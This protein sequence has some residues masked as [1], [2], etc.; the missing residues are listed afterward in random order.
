MN[1]QFGMMGALP[2]SAPKNRAGVAPHRADTGR[3]SVEI[4]FGIAFTQT[5]RDRQLLLK[6][7]EIM[8]NEDY[9]VLAQLMRR[10]VDEQERLDRKKI[11]QY[12]LNGPLDIPTIRMLP[13][14]KDLQVRA[15]FMALLVE[16]HWRQMLALMEQPG[17]EQA[18]A[19][20]LN[21]CD[22]HQV[23]ISD[24]SMALLNAYLPPFIDEQAKPFIGEFSDFARGVLARVSTQG[25]LGVLS[26]IGLGVPSNLSGRLIGKG[27]DQGVKQIKKRVEAGSQRT[28]ERPSTTF[29]NQTAAYVATYTFQ[30]TD[31]QEHPVEV[32]NRSG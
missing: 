18:I 13:K 4:Q 23:S 3:D 14:S 10:V 9:T 15:D 19:E 22:D 29:V 30:L 21:K 28:S 11:A 32:I 26:H 1:V 2:A 24:E 6:L 31:D 16:L 27:V 12:K 25:V 20:L 7:K 5:Q 17:G 8:A